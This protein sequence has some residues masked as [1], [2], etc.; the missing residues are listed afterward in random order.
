MHGFLQQHCGSQTYA[1]FVPDVPNRE[2]LYCGKPI[3]W[4]TRNLPTPDVL[5]FLECA[6]L[7]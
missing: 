2:S 1:V 7:G 6:E 3:L 4:Y 5:S